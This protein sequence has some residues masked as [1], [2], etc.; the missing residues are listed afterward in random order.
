M[1][2]LLMRHYVDAMLM[3]FIAYAMLRADYYFRGDAYDM[4][5]CRAL[6]LLRDT[7]LMPLRC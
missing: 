2:C 3:L 7:L 6:C 1:I 5:R 4:L